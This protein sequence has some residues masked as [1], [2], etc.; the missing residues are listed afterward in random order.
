[1]DPANLSE[2]EYRVVLAHIAYGTNPLN[3]EIP[4]SQEDQEEARQRLTEMIGWR[5]TLEDLD[6]IIATDGSVLPYRRP[7]ERHA[8]S[9]GGGGVLALLAGGGVV[10]AWILFKLIR[11]LLL[12]LQEQ[13][14]IG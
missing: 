11:I 8:G 3:R 4:I 1:M 2:K 9:S 12:V 13:G 14:L 7:A 5:P 6:Q 10:G